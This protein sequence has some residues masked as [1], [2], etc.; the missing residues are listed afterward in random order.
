MAINVVRGFRL[1]VVSV[2]IL[3]LMLGGLLAARS[4]K[5]PDAKVADAPAP[6]SE[7]PIQLVDPSGKPLGDI[8]VDPD[9]D[10]FVVIPAKTQ[11][12]VKW[13]VHVDGYD[14]PIKTFAYPGAPILIVAVPR[15]GF[16]LVTAISAV[17]DEPFSAQVRVRAKGGE[18]S[19]AKEPTT[20]A[21]SQRVDVNLVYDVDK[22][23][24]ELD[25]IL[26]S[27]VAKRLQSEGHAFHAYDFRSEAAVRRKL[28][29][30]ATKPGGGGV[31]ALIILDS[32]GH[33]LP[34]GRALKVPTT[35]D[36]LAAL[37]RKVAE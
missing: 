12:K 19:T 20:K 1:S 9:T 36:G 31:P 34:E 8:E 6:T 27:D 30:I 23:T 13:L 2:A 18:A 15:Q 24:P 37:V 4:Q 11:G 14:K 7:P 32:A 17:K 26:N 25:A 10:P 28:T 29:E 3:L 22:K 35:A 21:P 16:V 33:V 5:E